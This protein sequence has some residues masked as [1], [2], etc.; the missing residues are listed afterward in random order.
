MS[1]NNCVI[2]SITNHS[3]QFGKWHIAKDI[4]GIDGIPQTV[5]PIISKL[6]KLLINHYRPHKQQ[7]ELILLKRNISLCLHYVCVCVWYMNGSKGQSGPIDI[8]H[9]TYM[10][11]STHHPQMGS[12][13]PVQE[14]HDV[15]LL[16]TFTGRLTT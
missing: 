11:E 10:L 14:S 6:S 1:T 2:L 13:D 4:P 8:I 3:W 5:T 9:L 16:H 12:P 7:F 15:K